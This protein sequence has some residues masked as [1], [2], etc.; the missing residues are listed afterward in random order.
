MQSCINEE[1]RM[2][3]LGKGKC[4]PTQKANVTPHKKE[5]LANYLVAD[6]GYA[7]IAEVFEV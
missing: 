1:I 3:H 4:Y 2:A 6:A 5:C 7:C